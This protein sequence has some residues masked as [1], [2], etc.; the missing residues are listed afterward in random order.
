[1]TQPSTTASAR[2]RILLIGGGV[3]V[4][5]AALAAVLMISWIPQLPAEIAIH[6]NG[7]GADG[8]GSVWSL[9]FVPLGI[10][11]VFCA[12]SVGSALPTVEEERPTFKQ[13]FVLVTGMW[14]SALL[15]VGI[16]SSV[17][18][19]RGLTDVVAAPD[20]GP[21][22]LIG[23][24]VGLILA[25]IAWFVLPPADPNDGYGPVIDDED[26]DRPGS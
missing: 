17:A 9:V 19:Q 22:L 15:S 14:L 5:M 20:P 12:V 21:A 10:T 2:T 7:S 1:M 3:P 6:W 25:A 16:A 8:F 18:G 23:A 26:T 24:V 11:A 4:L 13:K